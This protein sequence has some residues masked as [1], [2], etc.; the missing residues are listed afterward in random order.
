MGKA[1]TGRLSTAC[2]CQATL[3]TSLTV[4][5]GDGDDLASIDADDDV[6]GLQIVIFGGKGDDTVTVGAGFPTN[7]QTAFVD[8]GADHDTFKPAAGNS[9]ADY[10]LLRIEGV[11]P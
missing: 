7:S 3:F 8:G 9:A 11:A 10:W 5:L 6:A 2:P 1:T 4:S